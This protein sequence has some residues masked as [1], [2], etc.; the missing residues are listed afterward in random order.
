MVKGGYSKVRRA[1]RFYCVQPQTPAL[2]GTREGAFLDQNLAGMVARADAR[3]A[4][5][6]GGGQSRQ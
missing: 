4:K 1:A 6:W 2:D 5:P 3:G